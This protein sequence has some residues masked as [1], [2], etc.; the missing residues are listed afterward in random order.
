V[1]MRNEKGDDFFVLLNHS[2]ACE[3]CLEQGE[4]VECCHN[5]AFLPPWKSLGLLT[6][7]MHL[8]RDKET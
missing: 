1:K 2:L 4:A 5:L 3:V 6:S 8:V 7:M